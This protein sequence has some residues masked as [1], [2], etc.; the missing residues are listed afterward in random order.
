MGWHSDPDMRDWLR[1]Q[2]FDES[3]RASYQLREIAVPFRGSTTAAE[4]REL[5]GLY[6]S[7]RSL[8]AKTASECLPAKLAHLGWTTVGL[9]GFASHMFD[10]ATWWPILG[11]QTQRFAE[12]LTTP[13]GMR[14]GGAFAGVCDSTLI[15]TA[16]AEARSPRHL[17]YALTL[18]SHLPLSPIKV[19]DDLRQRCL[20][21]RAGSEVCQLSATI[22]IGLTTL[23]NQLVRPGAR[24]VV[25][26]VGDHAPPFASLQDRNQY[27][28]EKVPAFILTP[29]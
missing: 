21:A 18:N 11:L 20:I 1:D 23:R 28:P 9:H 27:S 15:E 16:F 2:L 26:V 12:E 5:C 10:R 14:C 8:D 7:Y 25:V 13:D 17:V 4:L 24:P 6:G 3:V 22:G 29:R 19:P